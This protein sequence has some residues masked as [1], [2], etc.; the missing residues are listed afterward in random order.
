MVVWQVGKFSRLIH[1]ETCMAM[2][3]AT[4]LNGS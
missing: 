1:V 2:I 4:A 3:C